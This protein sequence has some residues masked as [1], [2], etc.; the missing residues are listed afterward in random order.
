VRDAISFNII[1]VNDVVAGIRVRD[2][3]HLRRASYEEENNDEPDDSEWE[4]IVK[5]VEKH[6]TKDFKAEL[7]RYI[8]LQPLFRIR[9]GS[10]FRWPPGNGSRRSK[11]SQRKG[12][13]T[14]P[15]PDSDIKF[16]FQFVF[17]N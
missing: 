12:E 4:K 7:D 2:A 3:I 8:C 13:K 5:E 11:K 14:Q 1:S 17:E 9:N 16:N 6:Y 10:A 15:K